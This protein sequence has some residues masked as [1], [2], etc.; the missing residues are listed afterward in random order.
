MP[1]LRFLPY[2]LD[3]SENNWL[4]S[5]DGYEKSRFIRPTTGAQNG[6]PVPLHREV[7]PGGEEAM[8]P[9]KNNGATV[10]LRPSK[11]L[12]CRCWPKRTTPKKH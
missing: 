12:A 11:I 2:A 7:N 9:I 5:R 3:G 6:V 4:H 10:S 1:P 8:L